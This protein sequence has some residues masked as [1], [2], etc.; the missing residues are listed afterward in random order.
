M[1]L[2]LAHSIPTTL[3]KSQE[4]SAYQIFMFNTNFVVTLYIKDLVY[5]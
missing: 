5:D 4:D 3:L 1:I 2:L